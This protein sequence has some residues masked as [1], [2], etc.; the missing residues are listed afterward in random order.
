MRGN[1]VSRRQLLTG[2]AGAGATGALVGTGTASLFTDEEGLR[3]RLTAGAFDLVVERAG[4]TSDGTVPLVIDA[5][6]GSERL[7]VRLPAE[8]SNPGYAWLR[9]VCPGANL[10]P[11]AEDIA[12]TLSYV[13]CGDGDTIATGSLADVAA[14]LRGGV[15]LDPR[16][17]GPDAVA[18]GGQTCLSSAGEIDLLFEWD[19]D[20]TTD[21]DGG[22]REL[23][24]LEFAGLQCRNVDG[25]R[26]PFPDAG[27]TANCETEGPS[28]E[29][30]G[31]SFCEVSAD[32]GDGCERVG[33]IEL[34]ADDYCGQT[35]GVDESYVAEGTYDL[36]A[37]GDDC[38]DTGYDLRITD[39]ETKD[40]G[41]ETVAVALELL[42]GDGPAPT[43]C[44]VRIKGGPE[45]VVYDSGFD[46]NATGRLLHA[47][48]KSGDSGGPS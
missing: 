6:T 36:C 27:T 16:C 14:Q 1:E 7:T 10:P 8:R 24:A 5:P 9:T 45:T 25:T 19:W 34:E 11:F 21:Y 2:L 29:R 35:D 23:V 17:L 4:E 3:A 15:P 20:L 44:A 18:P 30:H 41:T 28:P 47:P 40:G 22:P 38:V 39:T 46:G 42:D 12:V 43:L 33:K 37:D 26:S 48:A 13:D 32:L 31:I